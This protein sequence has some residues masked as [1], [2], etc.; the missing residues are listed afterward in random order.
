MLI[1]LLL[2]DLREG[3]ISTRVPVEW[4]RLRVRL[5]EGMVIIL[6]LIEVLPLTIILR[7]PLLL[8]VMVVLRRGLHVALRLPGWS[9]LSS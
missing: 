7:V 8:C 6:R 5:G 3:I 9:I 2:C 4:P 1:L